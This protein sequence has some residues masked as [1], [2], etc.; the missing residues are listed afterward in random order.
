MGGGEAWGDG[1]GAGGRDR[2]LKNTVC[3]GFPHHQSSLCE[4]VPPRRV[5]YLYTASSPGGLGRCCTKQT[6]RK[7]NEGGW[8]GGF[9]VGVVAHLQLEQ[10]M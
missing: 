10:T 9:S 3:G 8:V 5:G 2:V 4:V 6:R 7:F 1:C